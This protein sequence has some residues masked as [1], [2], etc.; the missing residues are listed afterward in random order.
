MVELKNKIVI[1]LNVV[2][3]ILIVGFFDYVT[4]LE[5]RI[6]PL[7]FI[8][9]VL[10]AWHLGQLNTIIFSLLA[11]ITWE[12]AMYL[13][14][15]QYSGTYVWVVNFFTQGS[16]FLIVGLLVA[17]LRDSLDREKALSRTDSLT[18]LSNSRSFY[19]LSSST[20]AL[21]QRHQRPVTL[22]YIDLDNFKHVN[23][24]LG[25]LKGDELLIRVA[26]ILKSS[27]RV[28]DVVARMG[29][30]EFAVLLPETNATDAERVLEK[31]RIELN[32]TS[33]FKETSVTA[34]IGAVS[35]I[36]APADLT[37]AIQDADTLMY[38]VKG[39]GK[40]R[41]QVKSITNVPP[42]VI[43]ND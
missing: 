22:A 34:S 39:S 24:T 14:G 20:L 11:V 37:L 31:I 38:K 9:L 26:G 16:A 41:V 42:P 30:D 2:I 33:Q 10:S 17:R 28:T 12:L 19:E 25:H 21:C 35:Y 29:G 32:Q 43:H 36:Y 27:L 18:G 4:G 40:N 15:R 7:Y 23:D 6:F 5:V 8:P 3:G 1:Q 13:G